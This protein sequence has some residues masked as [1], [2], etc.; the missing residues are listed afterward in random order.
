MSDES[1]TTWIPT[2]HEIFWAPERALF[3]ALDATLQLTIRSL[4][5][6]Y[7]DFGL[8][9]QGRISQDP[10][11]EP[12]V[13]PQVPLIERIVGSANEL[14]RLIVHFRV[15]LEE[16]NSQ[17]RDNSE[18]SQGARPDSEEDALPSGGDDDSAT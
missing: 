3:A 18:G 13:P 8:D 17:P 2:T 16:E 1:T 6:E 11:W 12:Y 14:R 15:A 7:N 9:H 5:A 4:R 10:D